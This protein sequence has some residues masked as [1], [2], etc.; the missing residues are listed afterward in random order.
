MNDI[1][2]NKLKK[3][4]IINNVPL[5][6]S[7]SAWCYCNITILKIIVKEIFQ[8]IQ[9][10]YVSLA[11]TVGGEEFCCTWYVSKAPGSGYDSATKVGWA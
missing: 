6:F 4:F 9:G 7:I 5:E 8:K 1:S 11:Y 3:S 2:K 10:L